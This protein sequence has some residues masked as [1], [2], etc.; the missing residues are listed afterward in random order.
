MCGIV[1]FTGPANPEL[2]RAM[3]QA[4]VHRGPDEDG[5]CEVPGVNLAMR[6][7]SIIDISGGRQPVANETGELRLVFNGEI[8]NHVDLR[9]G[10][11]ERGHAFRTDHSDT[12]TIVHLYEER[13]ADWASQANGMFAVAIW[14]TPR[15]RL[16]LARDRV[17]KKPLYYAVAGGEIIFASELKCLLLHPG[18]RRDMDP[19]AL[20][21]YLGMKNVSAPQSIFS[22]VRQLPA[23]H[24]LVW[25]NGEA[26]VRP[27]WRAD[28][29]PLPEP[30]SLEEAATEVR[31]LLTDAV[32]LRMDC[33]VPYGAYLSGGVDSS[34]VT[35]LMARLH[36]QPVKTFCLGYA[37]DATGQFAGKAQ[38][39]HYAREMS[40]RL[41]TEHHELIIDAAF[42]ADKMPEIV[43]S[44]DE[45]FSGTVSTFFLSILIHEHV[46]VALS[47]DGADELFA[48]YLPHRL[49]F[50]MEALLT[51]RAMGKTRREDLSPVELARLA[52]FDSP[53]QFAFLSRSAHA[54]QVG[55][56]DKIA[57]FP[58][59]ERLAL[60]SPEFL[61]RVPQAQRHDPYAG[62]EAALTSGDDALNRVLEVDQ[63]E[64]LQNQILP[65]VD[66]LSMAH[67][68]EVRCPFLDHR[69]VEYVNRLPGRYKIGGESGQPVN[70]RVLKAAVA[71]LLPPELISRPKE[72][73]VQPIYTWMHGAL[74]DW[75]LGCLDDLPEGMFSPAPLAELKARFVGG[76]ASLNARVWNLACLGLWWREYGLT[77][78]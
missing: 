49:A 39:I 42:F 73:F 11:M 31:R 30:P 6:R 13:G 70:K 24:S 59:E 34:A 52:P 74:K 53:A 67:S 50:P 9:Q 21:Q 58:M 66:R 78:P 7:L 1:G 35:A 28:F 48:S 56:R 63:A 54:S 43:R 22:A 4:I 38:D 3:N 60:F 8:Y 20:F 26:R 61:A 5:F 29:S 46:K 44:F 10:L 2:L 16:V 41:G 64:L 68:I 40:Q 76:D 45:P 47:G 33:D 17:G 75:T 37:D 25:E 62:L 27:Y 72:G 18:I 14:D 15:K 19:A 57:V 69:L 71:D 23:G 65:F 55:W 36:G 32:R 51:C 12:E 77:T